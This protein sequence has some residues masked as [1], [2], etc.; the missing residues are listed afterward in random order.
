MKETITVSEFFHLCLKK[1]KW[2]V[3][4]ATAFLLLAIA[5]L[6]ITPPK[7]TR[8]AQIL[9][10]DEGGIGG[11]M[12]QLGGL[13]EIG[14]FIG[15]GSSNV[16]NELCAME[17][18]WLLLNVVKQLNLD[19]NYVVKGIRNETLYGDQLP[20][21]VSFK[22]LTEEDDVRL[23]LD[24]SKNGDFKI[25]KIKKNDDK[26]DDE[27]SGHVNTSVKSSIG[28][29]EVKAT[30]YLKDMKD[31]EMT[32]TVTRSEPMSVVERLKK[33]TLTMAVGSRDASIIDIKCKDIS[34]QRATDMPNT[35]RSR[36]KTRTPRQQPR[37]V[38]SWTAWPRWRMN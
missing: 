1:W 3:V 7:Y 26:F 12:G 30:P 6:V 36:T 8:Q 25:Y 31:D 4:S 24:L 27:L 22:Q 32:I 2:F 28:E 17:S 11:L 34:K 10:R 5:Y 23:K 20:T 19:M 38:T 21:T 9:V 13:A 16:Y 15:F 37:S 14:G 18:P 29:I 35:A 33:Q